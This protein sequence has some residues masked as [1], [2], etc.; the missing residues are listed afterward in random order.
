MRALK[1][2]QVLPPAHHIAV[3][4]W[5]DIAGKQY[6]GKLAVTLIWEVFD[7]V[8]EEGAEHEW[9][10]CDDHQAGFRDR[11]QS[12]ASD[13]KL[14]D[15]SDILGIGIWGDSAP[16]HNRNGVYLLTWTVLTGIFR[17]R[18]RICGL[19]K[20]QICCC[21][22][23]GRC[24]FEKIFEFLAWQFTV[25]LTKRCP[26]TD[27]DNKPFTNQWRRKRQGSWMRARSLLIA[28]NADWQ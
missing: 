27:Q 20:H 16:T 17:Y 1:S 12:S 24:T 9:L 6:D 19:S 22:C 23:F 8:C 15:T 14:T 10:H 2:G 13:L 5:D 28:K 3:P 18:F 7:A 4:M 11:I 21:G 26:A 25:M